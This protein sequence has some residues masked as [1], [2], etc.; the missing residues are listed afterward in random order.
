MTQSPASGERQA[1]RGY[2]WQYDHIA[3]LVYDAL[4]D[5]DF[6]SVRLTDP[7]AGRLDDLVLNRR[8]RT[9]AYQFKSA[10]REG[11]ITFNQ[12]VQCQRTRSGGAAPSLVQSLADV[13]KFLKSQTGNV[14]VHLVTQQLASRNDHLGIRGDA[15]CPPRDDFASL[16]RQVLEPLRLGNL[17]VDE[18]ATGWHPP[19]TRL[20]EAT[21][22]EPEEFSLFLRALHLDLNAGLGVP[23]AP[24]T[25]RSDILAL[26]DA[27]KRRVSESFDVVD[28]DEIGVLKLMGWTQRTRLHSRHEFQSTSIHMLPFLRQSTNWTI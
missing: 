28:L 20:R 15:D 21:N 26:S 24:S 4:Y 17:T 10:E 22:S 5:G 14:H 7:E 27:L 8:G 19:L 16:I 11:Y 1:L 9:D 2:R 13:W 3:A 23:A 18:V 25:R 6:V 12:V